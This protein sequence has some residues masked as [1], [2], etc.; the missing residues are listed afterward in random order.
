MTDLS[1]SRQSRTVT[2]FFDT[3]AMAQ[4][5]VDDLVA[6]GLSESD[7]R[8]TEGAGETVVSD[9][10]KATEHKGFWAE[11]KDLF[12][13]EEDRYS[14]AEGLTRGGHLLSVQTTDA[15]HDRVLDILDTDGAV[16]MNER[17]ADWRAA[18][19]T[20]Y[21]AGALSPEDRA[22]GVRSAQAPDTPVPAASAE[23]VAASTSVVDQ[24][25][26]AAGGTAT[27]DL[28]HGRTRLRSYI[29]E[30]RDEGG[31]DVDLAPAVSN[32]LGSEAVAN[33]TVAASDLNRITEHMDVIA[34]DGI[35]IG[36][37]DHLDGPDRVKLTRNASPDG[38]HHFIPVAWIDHVDT[39]VHLNKAS[40]AAKAAW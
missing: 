12:L 22:T 7:I 24:S 2:A 30:R 17:E 38:Q 6:A 8:L 36:T 28:S 10:P 40:E 37:V 5:A 3:Q 32:P 33:R 27:R 21:S 18:G 31:V 1:S 34:S 39:H 16:D 15:N 11:L 14:Y 25:V 13:P 19:W 9:E 29:P 35:T 26:F 4:K 23:P 20:G